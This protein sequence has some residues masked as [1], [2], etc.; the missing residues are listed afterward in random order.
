MFRLCYYFYIKLAV[1]AIN[2]YSAWF[3]QPSDIVY[4][5]NGNLYVADQATI[6][7]KTYHNLKKISLV[8]DSVITIAGGAT[9]VT[10]I[11]L[12]TFHILS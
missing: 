3:N 1:G 6:Q 11:T 4:D 9:G 7:G 8:Y 5:N 12:S 2:T 10:F